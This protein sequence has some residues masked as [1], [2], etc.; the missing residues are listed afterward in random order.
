[1]NPLAA[2]KSAMSYADVDTSRIY[3]SPPEEK[4]VKDSKQK[5]TD[6]LVQYNL[7]TQ[8]LPNNVEYIFRTPLLL[9]K[10]GVCKLDDTTKKGAY[11]YSINMVL[12]QSNPEL[13]QLTA[14]LKSNYEVSIAYLDAYKK[15]LKMPKADPDKF[16]GMTKDKTYFPIDKNTGEV[17]PGRSPTFYVSFEKYDKIKTKIISPADGTEL[18]WTLFEGKDFRAQLI[19]HYK[20]IYKGA[21]QFSL[22]LMVRSV[23]MGEMV[24]VNPVEA[25]GSA[26]NDMS[27]Q[28]GNK[29]AEQL[30]AMKNVGAGPAVQVGPKVDNNNSGKSVAELLSGAPNLPTNLSLNEANGGEGG[31]GENN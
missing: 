26:F 31:D 17:I 22:Q 30:A 3:V 21:N 27:K 7:G 4:T 5:Y 15:E 2:S 14:L 13:V 11:N 19:L 12:D 10:G 6:L 28:F 29:F 8:E 1:M 18:P 16:R 20:K 23:L 9:C 24:D 25:Y